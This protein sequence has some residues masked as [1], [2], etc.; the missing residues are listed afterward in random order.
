MAGDGLRRVRRREVPHPF[1]SGWCRWLGGRVRARPPARGSCPSLLG[2]VVEAFSVFVVVDFAPGVALGENRPRIVGG[3]VAV[4]AAWPGA[5][6]EEESEAEED[7]EEP[8]QW[9]QGPEEEP[10][11]AP[12]GK[13]GIHSR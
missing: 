6:P 11:P 5:A 10:V 12:V 13:D 7:E 8:E 9:D 2:E 3:V 4:P 1:A